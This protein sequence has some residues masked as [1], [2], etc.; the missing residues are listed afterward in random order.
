MIAMADIH[1]TADNLVPK[2]FCSQHYPKLV[3]GT[4]GEASYTW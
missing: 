2:V 4:A 3:D 1:S